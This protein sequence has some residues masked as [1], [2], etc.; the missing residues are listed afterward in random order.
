MR[1]TP[2]AGG[3]LADEEWTALT[4]GLRFTETGWFPADE[5]HTPMDAETELMWPR[6]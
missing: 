6:L 4:D 3:E 5:V 2:A 1:N